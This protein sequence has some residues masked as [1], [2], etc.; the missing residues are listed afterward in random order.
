MF[1]QKVV[2]AME[3]IILLVQMVLL[4]EVEE[5]EEVVNLETLLDM[6]V[7]MAVLES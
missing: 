6:Q 5:V 1:L 2:E 4:K 7:A 3:E